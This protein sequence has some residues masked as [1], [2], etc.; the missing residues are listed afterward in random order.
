ME[1][2]GAD[3]VVTPVTT[4]YEFRTQRRVPK[5]GFVQQALSHLLFSSLTQRNTRLML[6][7]WG[8]NNG[9]TVTAGILANRRRVPFLFLCLS[10]VSTHPFPPI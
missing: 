10:F 2:R 4:R 6:V 8:G 7:G 9:T 5:F 1:Q 3:W